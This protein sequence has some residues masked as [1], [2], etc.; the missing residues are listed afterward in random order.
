MML[1]SFAISPFSISE[2]NSVSLHSP[3][4]S[5]LHWPVLL[6]LPCPGK[7]LNQEVLIQTTH[8]GHSFSFNFRG[9]TETGT[10]FAISIRTPSCEAGKTESCS[11]QPLLTL[12]RYLLEK[13]S[14]TEDGKNDNILLLHAKFTQLSKNNIVLLYCRVSKMTCSVSLGTTTCFSI[15]EA[16]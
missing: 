3:V 16:Y 11:C 9:N 6:L 7:Y 1:C 12:C 4:H 10:F 8:Q 14:L 5:P 13:T 15:I 2:R